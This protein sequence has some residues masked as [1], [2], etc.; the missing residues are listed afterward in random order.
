MARHRVLVAMCGLSFSGKSTF[1]RALAKELDADIVSFDAINEER[2][3]NGG[4]GIPI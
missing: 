2:G 3:L 1:A 4:D